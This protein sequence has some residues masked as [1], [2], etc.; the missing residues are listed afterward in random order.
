MLGPGWAWAD[1]EFWQKSIFFFFK[2]KRR[3]EEIT[4]GPIFK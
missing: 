4:A 2:K 1:D 3:G